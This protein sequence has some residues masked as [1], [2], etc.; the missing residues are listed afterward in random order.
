MT[1]TYTHGIARITH[2][3]SGWFAIITPHNSHGPF[4]TSAEVEQYLDTNY[5][6]GG[7]RFGQGR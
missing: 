2:K 1:T 7:S 4:A 6:V 3:R 5:P